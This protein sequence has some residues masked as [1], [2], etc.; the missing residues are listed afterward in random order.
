MEIWKVAALA[1]IG[2]LWIV[3]VVFV[4]WLYPKKQSR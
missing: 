1:V 3:G 2:A 4:A